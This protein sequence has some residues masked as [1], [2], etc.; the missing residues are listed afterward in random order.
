MLTNVKF[1]KRSPNLSGRISLRELCRGKAQAVYIR[2]NLGRKRKAG[3]DCLTKFLFCRWCNSQKV[4]A[5][6]YRKKCENAL[7]YL[8]IKVWHTNRDHPVQQI[9]GMLWVIHLKNNA[10]WSLTVIILQNTMREISSQH[11]AHAMKNLTKTTN[12]HQ[13]AGG[14]KCI[15]VEKRYYV[16]EYAQLMAVKNSTDIA[17]SMFV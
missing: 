11:S 1:L 17:K 4:N 2:T 13:R 12:V 16:K 10:T 6:K 9:S 7:K 14:L 3:I 5:L 15:W 8:H